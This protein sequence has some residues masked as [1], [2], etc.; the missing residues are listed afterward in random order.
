MLATKSG[1]T[2]LLEY[3]GKWHAVMKDG[4]FVEA[5]FE[6]QGKIGSGTGKLEKIVGIVTHKGKSLPETKLLIWRRF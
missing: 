5:P 4:Q 6:A 2:A 3:A 1:D